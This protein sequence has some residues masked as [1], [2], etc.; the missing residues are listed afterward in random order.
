MSHNGFCFNIWCFANQSLQSWLCPQFALPLPPQIPFAV[1]LPD[2]NQW[3]VA[4]CCDVTW[5]SD[6]HWM[7]S[8]DLEASCHRVGETDAT[9][10]QLSWHSAC[11]LLR[12]GPDPAKTERLFHLQGWHTLNKSVLAYRCILFRLHW[13]SYKEPVVLSMSDGMNDNRVE[14]SDEDGPGS[15]Y[16]PGFQVEGNDKLLFLKLNNVAIHI[17]LSGQLR[18][19]GKAI[20]SR[21]IA[22]W[23]LSCWQNL[24]HGECDPC[25]AQYSMQWHCST[26]FSMRLIVKWVNPL[27]SA[28]V[29][30]QLY[31]ILVACMQQ[32]HRTLNGISDP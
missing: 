18:G 13:S 32:Q 3:C 24:E 9:Q 4:T 27:M 10:P 2:R 22:E 6:C 19:S 16:K 14:P 31:T 12:G 28:D 15:S 17:A 11:F 20:C 30:E 7:S 29:F 1:T 5:Y 23:Y 26:F 8:V 25:E 21:L